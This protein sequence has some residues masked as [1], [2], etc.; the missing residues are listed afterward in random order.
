[1]SR[2]ETIATIAASLLGPRIAN[3]A[4]TGITLNIPDVELAEALRAA[5]YLLDNA[6]REESR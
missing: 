1:M 3:Q 6:K 2:P 5:R 4:L